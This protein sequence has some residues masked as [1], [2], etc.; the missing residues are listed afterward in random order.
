MFPE[1]LLA[2]LQVLPILHDSLLTLYCPCLILIGIF[3]VKKMGIVAVSRSFPESFQF[4]SV[5]KQEYSGSMKLS[6]LTKHYR[7]GRTSMTEYNCTKTS[8]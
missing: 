4:L 2:S 6:T 8:T 3:A 1:A 5:G 7:Q